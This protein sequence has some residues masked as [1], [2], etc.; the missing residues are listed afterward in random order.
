MLTLWGGLINGTQS[1]STAMIL[2]DAAM[3]YAIPA[4]GTAWEEVPQGAGYSEYLCPLIS[5][6]FSLLKGGE[7]LPISCLSCAPTVGN[8]GPAKRRIA[9][10]SR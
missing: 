1:S 8:V 3:D 7:G 6:R 4:G 9:P 2:Q 10:G 5:R